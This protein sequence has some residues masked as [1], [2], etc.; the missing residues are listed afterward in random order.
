M[1]LNIQLKKFKKPALLWYSTEQLTFDK[2]QELGM[3]SRLDEEMGQFRSRIA[4][5]VAEV[6]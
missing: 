6:M 1:K 4:Q 5:K 3:K 2:A